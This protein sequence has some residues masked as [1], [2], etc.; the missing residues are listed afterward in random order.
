MKNNSKRYRVY[1]ITGIILLLVT[2]IAAMPK[3]NVYNSISMEA[4][5]ELPDASAF[6]RIMSKTPNMS[7]I[8]M[9]LI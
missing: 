8:W 7:Q 9:A 1:I 5:G 6:L 2:V 4:G 3:N